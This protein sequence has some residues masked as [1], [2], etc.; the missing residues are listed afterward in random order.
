[1]HAPPTT[2]SHLLLQAVDVRALALAVQLRRQPV[3]HQP[4]LPLL[5]L[6]R[7]RNELRL[8]EV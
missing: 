4:P 6:R 8:C 7:H 5:L 1:M 3:A 2:L